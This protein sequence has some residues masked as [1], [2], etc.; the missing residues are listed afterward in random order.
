MPEEAQKYGD[1]VFVG[2][3]EL[4]LPQF[5]I[6]YQNG[7]PKKRYLSNGV[8]ADKMPVP[9]RDLMIKKGFSSY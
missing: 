9:R 1:S 5:F 6:D 8:Q 2:S 4:T 7:Q 3:A